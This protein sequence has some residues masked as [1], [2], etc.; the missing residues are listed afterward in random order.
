MKLGKVNLFFF[1]ERERV[2]KH[3]GEGQRE[4]EEES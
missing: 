3:T 2:C 4:G 1:F